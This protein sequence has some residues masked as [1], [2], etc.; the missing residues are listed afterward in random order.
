MQKLTV[1]SQGNLVLPA[2]KSLPVAV[3]EEVKALWRSV[4]A[5]FPYPDERPEKK[6]KP[7]VGDE[8]ADKPKNEEGPADADATAVVVAA[9]SKWPARGALAEAD[10][11]VLQEAPSAIPGL[12]LLLCKKKAAVGDLHMHVFLESS[13]DAN[14]KVKSGTFVGR[15]SEGNS[16]RRR[17][18]H[19]RK[20]PTAGRSRALQL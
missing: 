13:S 14:I 10:W 4:R 8:E 18:H 6:Q 19:P 1:D 9:G 2:L 12:T 20:P 11:S 7:A 3:N 15:A 5:E 17:K 16:T